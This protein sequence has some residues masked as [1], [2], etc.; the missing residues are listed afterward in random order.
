MADIFLELLGSI[1]QF[2]FEA[3]FEYLIASLGDLLSRAMSEVFQGPEVQNAALATI[4]YVLFGLILGAL[5]LLFFPHRLV[6]ASRVH[7]MNL[8]VIP[9]ITGLMMSGT[10]AALRRLG[11]K[12]T[13]LE[14]FSSGYAFAFG[15]AL[16]RFFFAK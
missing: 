8:F 3:L 4:G 14:R 2:F 9:L 15:V 10:G 5:S 12:V 16:V 1:F 11:K 6:H 7:G 13:R